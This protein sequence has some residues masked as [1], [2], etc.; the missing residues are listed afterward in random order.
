MTWWRG[1][2]MLPFS[3]ER[4]EQMRDHTLMI[5]LVSL[6]DL[7]VYTCQAYNGLG[8]AASW[9]VSLLTY[10]PVQVQDVADREFLVYVI[11]TGRKPGNFSLPV[12]PTTTTT[13]TTQRS[14][15]QP[16]EEDYIHRGN[17]NYLGN[18][19]TAE[20]VHVNRSLSARLY[21]LSPR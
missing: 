5:R 20:S 4:Y 16:S 8:R 3:S 17:E 9:S 18:D 1:E 10:G 21:C 6:R 15:V 2:R 14:V 7:G 11:D 12:V 19:L 13:T